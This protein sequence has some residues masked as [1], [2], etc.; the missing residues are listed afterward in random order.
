[1]LYV[2]FVIAYNNYVIQVF[3]E[4]TFDYLLKPVIPNRLTKTMS[5]RHKVI[6]QS[7]Q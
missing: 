5:R 2:V 3:K 1:M 6:Q 7:T 4:N